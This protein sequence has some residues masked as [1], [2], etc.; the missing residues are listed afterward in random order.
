MIVG[1][2]GLTTPVAG[3]KSRGMVPLRNSVR[4]F[5]AAQIAAALGVCKRNIHRRA[6][7]EHWPKR[8]SGNRFLFSPP[9]AVLRGRLSLSAAAQCRRENLSLAAL[10]ISPA[11]IAEVARAD[12]RLRA[13]LLLAQFRPA[14]GIA[15]ALVR[16][17]R[18]STIPCSVTSLRRWAGAWQSCGFAGL[19]ESRRDRCGAKVRAQ[20]IGSTAGEMFKP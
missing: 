17:S 12:Q 10:R 5:S 14:F 1:N 7:R 6:A 3:A 13:L 2:F 8:R 4:W 16:A 15:R 20:R 19:L 18:F 11:Q 9:P